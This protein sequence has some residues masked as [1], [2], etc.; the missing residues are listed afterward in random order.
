MKIRTCIPRA[1]Y[2]RTLLLT[3]RV[4]EII[5]LLKGKSA[6]HTLNFN[7]SFHMAV[8]TC[9]LTASKLCGF[10]TRIVNQY[11]ILSQSFGSIPG[12]SYAEYSEAPHSRP[13]QL[14]TNF[15]PP[16]NVGK[17]GLGN[18]RHTVRLTYPG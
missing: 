2:P 6:T 18:W 14:E 12:P 10:G 1:T 5:P 17:E 15:Q 4:L 9:C 3:P 11:P 16:P 7:Q 8:S 13:P